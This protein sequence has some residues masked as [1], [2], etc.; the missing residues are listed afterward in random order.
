MKRSVLKLLL[1]AIPLSMMGEL[2]AAT[3]KLT[4]VNGTESV[5]YLDDPRTT[6]K[7]LTCNVS[8]YQGTACPPV[9]YPLNPNSVNWDKR[10]NMEWIDFTID[11]QYPASCTLDSPAYGV[12]GQTYAA[13]RLTEV[14]NH[15]AVVEFQKKTS[16][17]V[18][19]SEHG[20]VEPVNKVG[21]ETQLEIIYPVKIRCD[22]NVG[23]ITATI[24]ATLNAQKWW[25][26]N[27]PNNRQHKRVI[28]LEYTEDTSFT[29][30]FEPRTIHLS[31]EVNKYLMTES[32]LN[33]FTSSVE[34]VSIAL[35]ASELIEYKNDGEWV[36]QYTKE[37]DLSGSGGSHTLSLRVRSATP[38]HRLI[39]IPA[40][41]TVI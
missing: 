1:C 25:D 40:T 20:R 9:P 10:Y 21:D 36:K 11:Y 8:G 14:G 18:S 31:G 23:P 16:G 27:T 12:L 3:Y 39:N 32:T 6:S 2:Y 17:P 15:R 29:A 38:G 28:D 24:V 7:P 19:R 5:T 34:R 26:G 41:V 30:S 4:S 37:L 22:K 35:P 13:G 33:V